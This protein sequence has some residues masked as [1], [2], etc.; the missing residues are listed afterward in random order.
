MLQIFVNS[1]QMWNIIGSLSN[2]N[3]VTY[4]VDKLG[5]YYKSTFRS[6]NIQ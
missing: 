6:V 4:D 1:G 2:D 3:Y 5:A